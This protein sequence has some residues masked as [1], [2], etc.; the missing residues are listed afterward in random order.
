[1]RGFFSLR[2][3]QLGPEWSSE[4]SSERET[5][6]IMRQESPS[7]VARSLLLKLLTQVDRGGRDSV[8]LNARSAQAYF[9]VSDLGG[10]DAIHAALETA[11]AAGGVTLVWG[12]GTAAQDLRR[13]RIQD[14][15][16]LAS[17]LGVSRTATQARAIVLGLDQLMTDAPGWLRDAYAQALWQW[18]RGGAPYRISAADTLTATSLFRAARAI[19]AGEQEGLDLRRFSARLLGDPRALEALLGR[20][21][22]LLRRNPDWAQWPEDAGLFRALGLEPFPPPLF[23][24]GPLL[25]DYGGAVWDLSPLRPY[26]GLAP[27][28]MGRIQAPRPLP[29]LLTI[30][31]LAS[32]HRHVREL[33][34]DGV[35]LCTDGYPA[36]A[37]IRV[38]ALLDQGLP[39]DCPFYHWGDRDLEGLRIYARILAACPGHVVQPHLMAGPPEGVSSEETAPLE[40]ST[41]GSARPAGNRPGPAARPLWTREERRALEQAIAQGGPTA[42][43]ATE[44]LHR[45]LGPQG[46][47]ALDPQCP[48]R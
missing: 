32:F 5:V 21:A 11:Q 44:W 24:K 29:Y 35:I 16:R 14:P 8:P 46:Q 33:P 17:W 12:R 30:E 18:R 25:L 3:G 10:R 39:A 1:M 27:E 4:R 22:S 34:D 7:Q 40:V 15:D 48:L 37:L 13:I 47:A 6:A 19:A 42:H 31:N 26:V 28:E 23:L 45:G 9:A 38:L 36:P 2:A 20:L 41:P 43:L